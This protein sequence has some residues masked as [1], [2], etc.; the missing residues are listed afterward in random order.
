MNGSTV[1]LAVNPPMPTKAEGVDAAFD[2]LL[3]HALAIADK[4]VMDEQRLRRALAN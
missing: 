3:G 2:A 1:A 4:V